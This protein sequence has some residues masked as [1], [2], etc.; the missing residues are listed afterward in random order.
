MK[1]SLRFRRGLCALVLSSFLLTGC[2][3][4]SLIGGLILG[5]GAVGGFFYYKNRKTRVPGSEVPLVANSP[6]ADSLQNAHHSQLVELARR[7]LPGIDAEFTLCSYRERDSVLEL[8]LELASESRYSDARE[9]RMD[10]V[11]KERS[12]VVEPLLSIVGRDFF[13]LLPGCGRLVVASKYKHRNYLTQTDRL[14]EE[15]LFGVVPLLANGGLDLGK[16]EFTTELYP[17]KTAD[18]SAP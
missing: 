10:R 3:S 7:P 14:K 16:A 15:T 2:S 4:A 17:P 1:G 18:K 12:R 8:Y 13:P 9:E 6:R 11:R 5:G